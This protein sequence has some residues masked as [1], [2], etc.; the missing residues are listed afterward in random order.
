MVRA[1]TVAVAFLG[2][3]AWW[4]IAQG[5]RRAVALTEVPRFGEPLE[6]GLPVGILGAG[7]T[8]IVDSAEVDSIGGVWFGTRRGAGFCW[9]RA[10]NIR[11][12]TE[13]PSLASPPPARGESPRTKRAVMS[14]L[15]EHPDWPRRVV[16]AIRLGQVCIDMTGAQLLASWGEPLQKSKAFTLGLGEHDLWFYKSDSG[17]LLTVTLQGDRVI[18]WVK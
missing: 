4:Q 18:G 16:N 14:I 15:R 10:D 2:V 11:Y 9:A 12:V 1:F 8:C 3:L 17:A 5:A 7:D 13:R 6:T